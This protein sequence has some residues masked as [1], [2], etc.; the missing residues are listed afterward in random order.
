MQAKTKIKLPQ[1]SGDYND[2]LTRNT[3]SFK[4]LPAVSILSNKRTNFM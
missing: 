3:K 1:S 2:S 4:I